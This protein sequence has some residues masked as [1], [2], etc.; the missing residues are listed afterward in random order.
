MVSQAHLLDITELWVSKS[1]CDIGDYYYEMTCRAKRAWS[2]ICSS[3]VHF[4]DTFDCAREEKMG[5]CQ[6]LRQK[7]ESRRSR[8]LLSGHLA[9]GVD[10]CF[11]WRGCFQQRTCTQ[12]G[13]AQFVFILFFHATRRTRRLW[14][15]YIYMIWVS[16]C[17]CVR[18]NM[19][20]LIMLEGHGGICA[21]IIC[22]TSLY[23]SYAETYKYY[24]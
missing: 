20:H 12:A 2:F 17:R 7:V 6:R 13:C 23:W 14:M 16:V 11:R 24:I 4:W 15:F 10:I 9:V 21:R 3:Y 8:S 22:H 19:S 18:G 5:D 1:A